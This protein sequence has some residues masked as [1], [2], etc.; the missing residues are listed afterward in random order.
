MQ[1]GHVAQHDLGDVGAPDAREVR[2]LR[3]MGLLCFL[4]ALVE[5]AGRIIVVVK[6]LLVKSH[7]T[8]RLGQEA[9]RE[10]RLHRLLEVGKR[11][12]ELALQV[13]ALVFG[14]GWVLQLVAAAVLLLAEGPEACQRVDELA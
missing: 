9:R 14:A 5:A 1:R 6:A 3:G 11:G 4:P 12:G 7:A 8:A 13:S 10:D 2:R